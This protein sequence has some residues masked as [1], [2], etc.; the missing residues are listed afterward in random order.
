[1]GKSK[2]H[3]AAHRNLLS[4][5]FHT[6][7]LAGAT[8]VSVALVLVDPIMTVEGDTLHVTAGAGPDSPQLRFT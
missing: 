4:G 6:I 2:A 8:I 7:K 1:M 5:E 3:A